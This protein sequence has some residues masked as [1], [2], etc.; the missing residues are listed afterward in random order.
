M[1]RQMR[2][3]G[4]RATSRS[5]RASR[6]EAEQH[7]GRKGLKIAIE[8]QECPRR[9]VDPD[10]EALPCRRGWQRHE[11]RQVD[12]VA[13]QAARDCQDHRA[14]LRLLRDLLACGREHVPAGAEVV[15]VLAVG[16]SRPGVPD[17][18]VE[19]VAGV[20]HLLRPVGPARRP[21]QPLLGPA[22]G[23]RLAVREQRRPVGRAR[24]G[25]E[26]PRALVF[27][28]RACLSRTGRGC[29]RGR[30]RGSGRATRRLS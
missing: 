9:V 19:R 5:V 21:E 8:P 11:E 27:L 10:R 1:P 29:G 20:S 3:P 16:Q 14:V 13:P 18:A 15:Q 4:P 22:T 24:S 28:D 17:E 30:R 7:L 26:A 25:A 6:A 12:P 2:I 23:N